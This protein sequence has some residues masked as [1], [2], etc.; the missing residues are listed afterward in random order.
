M[1]AR[2]I[3]VADSSRARIFAYQGLTS[4]LLELAALSHTASRLHD[5]VLSAD[6]PGRSYDSTGAGRHAMEQATSI[7][8]QEAITF[9]R[10]LTA[11][12]EKAAESGKLASLIVI[13]PPA[14]LGHL[15]ISYPDQVRKLVS[16]EIDKNLVE[17]TAEQIRE[18]IS[19]PVP[20]I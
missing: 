4:P 1:N 14:F 16:S 15:R 9:A 20:F 10:E 7:R 11:Y 2:W 13:A 6:A 8:K 17:A 19:E 3:I 12:L 18:Q 5:R